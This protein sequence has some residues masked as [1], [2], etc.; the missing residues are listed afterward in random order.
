MLDFM[1][2]AYIYLQPRQFP[3]Q[4][5]QHRRSL[6][7]MGIDLPLFLRF[8]GN[9]ELFKKINSAGGREARQHRGDKSGVATV[10]PGKSAVGIGK[11]AA[12]ITGD[13][14]FLTNA[15]LALEQ[16]HFGAAAGGADGGHQTG[17]AA[18]DDDHPLFWRHSALHHSDFQKWFITR[19]PGLSSR[20]FCKLP[21]T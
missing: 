21:L 1:A 2:G 17:T 9:A 18:T 6:L 20:A 3:A 11:I 14:E 19:T 4:N 10:E 16:H 8:T 5:I 15:V 12:A 7:G 13:Q